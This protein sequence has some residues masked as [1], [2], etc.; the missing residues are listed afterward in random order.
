M[1][2]KINNTTVIDNGRVLQNIESTFGNYD[3]FQP[4]VNAITTALNFTL[5]VMTRSALTA[6]TTFTISA[7]TTA[8]GR[9]S[10]LLLDRGTGGFTPLFNAPIYFA[11]AVEPVWTGHR[12]WV[13]TFV[14]YS[15]DFIMANA[16]GYTW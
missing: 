3:N 12:Y 1:A 10:V 11:N 9:S 6:N 7:G 15:S 8:T 5:P 14:C 16:A 2:I 4:N 13:I